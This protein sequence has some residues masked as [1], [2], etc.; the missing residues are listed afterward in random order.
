M[1]TP[2][3]LG[4]QKWGLWKDDWFDF[5]EIIIFLDAPQSFDKFL[6]QQVGGRS[7]DIIVFPSPGIFGLMGPM[8]TSKTGLSFRCDIWI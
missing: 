2:I 3:V 6:Q 4:Y 8:L 5:P 1:N 7:I